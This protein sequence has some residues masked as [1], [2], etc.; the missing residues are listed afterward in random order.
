MK[1]PGGSEFRIADLIVEDFIAENKLKELN[2]LMK[3]TKDIEEKMKGAKCRIPH[4]Y[5]LII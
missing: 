2:K 4:Y 3:M 5:F 1:M